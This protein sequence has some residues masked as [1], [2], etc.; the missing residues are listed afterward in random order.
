MLEIPVDLVITGYMNTF[1]CTIL[2]V[3]VWDVRGRHYDTSH[4]VFDRVLLRRRT[5][6]PLGY[7]T[8]GFRLR[9]ALTAYARATVMRHTGFPITCRFRRVMS[10]SSSCCEC[11]ADVGAAMDWRGTSSHS[12]SESGT[13][14]A[15]CASLLCE[16]RDFVTY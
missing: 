16:P 12:L 9:V 10:W 2:S 8:P 1:C 3:S 6:E 13:G 4:R 7:V 14:T 15:A 5:C 11:T